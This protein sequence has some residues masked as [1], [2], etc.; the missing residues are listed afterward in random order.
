MASLPGCRDHN[1]V[2]QMACQAC[3]EAVTTLYKQVKEENKQVKEENKQVKEENKQVKEE[4][5]QV[6]EENNE[7]K[8]KFPSF[9][10]LTEEEL[11]IQNET[12]S[13]AHTATGHLPAA[14]TEMDIPEFT[15]PDA[16]L[17]F[18]PSLRVKS[19]FDSEPSVSAS[20]EALVS[21]VIH[22]LG[23]KF[24]LEAELEIPMMDTIPDVIL[25]LVLNKVLAGTIEVKKHPKT[26]G[27]R[28]KIFGS[29]TE[30]AG[31]VFEQLFLARANLL[32]VNSVGLLT[33]Y[34]SWQLVSMEDLAETDLEIQK[35]LAFFD[36]KK[37]A[38]NTT[39]DRP[40]TA[41]HS[42][43]R[44]KKEDE[45]P[46]YNNKIKASQKPAQTSE[47]FAKGA[48]DWNR[49]QQGKPPL[50]NQSIERSYYA[51]KVVNFKDPGGSEKVFELIAVYVLL[52]LKAFRKYT[53]SNEDI[54]SMK[55]FAARF[56]QP[57]RKTFALR[58]IRLEKHID[59]YSEFCFRVTNNVFFAVKQL[60]YGCN[61]VCC[62]SINQKGVA[63]VL[64]FLH[65]KAAT[66]SGGML[67]AAKEE[68]ERWGEIYRLSAGAFAIDKRVVIAMPYLEVPS[69]YEDRL[70][71]MKGEED[72]PLYRGLLKFCEQGY[73]HEEV[74]W[75]HIGVR[76]GKY[77]LCFLCD[78]GHIRKHTFSGEQKTEWVRANFNN[79]KLRNVESDSVSNGSTSQVTRGVNGHTDSSQR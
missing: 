28:E 16:F 8:R 54:R 40:Q 63:C 12:A 41:V 56:L 67:K 14:V 32:G 30:V 44:I 57:S 19:S 2:F 4:N 6:K 20:V 24:V 50:N 11:H 26:K 76:S 45:I 34:N 21:Q 1:G 17:D 25:K 66:E 79:L 52:V 10:D 78:L 47:E 7:M 18:R 73:T 49:K 74:Y 36:G 53:E 62:L 43:W 22:A 68:A 38:P 58:E 69:N 71:L 64:K 55:V 35:S 72:S 75:H 46:V 37:E 51:S 42:K 39:P 9:R 3:V 23:F 77:D 59:F 60:G 70:R 65:P 27:E 61:G 48:R 33:T 15:L 5:K 29:N 31:E 13:S